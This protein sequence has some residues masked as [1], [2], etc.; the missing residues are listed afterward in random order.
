LW[1]DF[2]VARISFNVAYDA[3]EYRFNMSDDSLMNLTPMDSLIS[4]LSSVAELKTDLSQLSEL[5]QS[6]DVSV[7]LPVPDQGMSMQI[8]P[9]SEHAN[10]LDDTKVPDEKAAVVLRQ[11]LLSAA[12]S[13]LDACTDVR[14]MLLC[15]RQGLFDASEKVTAILTESELS[16]MEAIESKVQNSGEHETNTFESHDTTVVSPFDQTV[17]F[18]LLERQVKNSVEEIEQ[19]KLEFQRELAQIASELNRFKGEFKKIYLFK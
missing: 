4:A 5:M 18:E 2:F 14:K 12:R 8:V 15:H 17:V 19:H 9:S 16:R 1:G 3:D 6:Q 7:G 10:F 11:N 13:L